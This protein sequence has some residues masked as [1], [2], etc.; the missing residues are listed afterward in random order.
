MPPATGW[1]VAAYGGMRGGNSGFESSDS[2]SAGTPLT[3]R[4]R[5][6]AALALEAPY[7]DHRLLQVYLAHQRTRLVLGPAA[8]PGTPTTELPLRVSTLHL[9]GVNYFEG[10][11][12]R[13]PY[14]VGGLGLT[15]LSPNLPGTT[16]R[17]RWSMHI[18]LGHE[19]ALA[20][21]LSL[22]MELRGHAALLRSEGGF[23]C[24]GGCTVFVRGDTLTQVEGLL[25]LRVG[26]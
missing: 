18:G 5:P 3:L 2:G 17:T 24:S 1:G 26:F 12:G 4:S 13:G 23:F 14:V 11:V 7:D 6:A 9:G 20:R 10:P 16:A 21:A 19:W 15:H 8:S 25:G 22:R